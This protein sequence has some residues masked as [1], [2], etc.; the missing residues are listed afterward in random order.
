MNQAQE[1]N[2]IESKPLQDSFISKLQTNNTTVAIYLTNGIK[3]VGKI[4]GF[5]RHVLLLGGATQQIIYK[6][7]VS[8]LQVATE[9]H[10]PGN[11]K[12]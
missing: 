8:T 1:Q 6:H 4:E 7:A 9:A 12:K 3:L 5:D 11:H 10:M 2:S